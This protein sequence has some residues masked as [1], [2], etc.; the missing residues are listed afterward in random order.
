[1]LFTVIVALIQIQ[2]C[3]N[4]AKFLST[5]DFMIEWL[6]LA[7]L[8]TTVLTIACAAIAWLLFGQLRDDWNKRPAEIRVKL[9][10]NFSSVVTIV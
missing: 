8:V 7:I 3:A 9:N 1:M 2:C 6:V 10:D 5:E 4:L